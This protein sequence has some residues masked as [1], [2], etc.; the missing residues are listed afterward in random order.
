MFN[1]ESNMRDLPAGGSEIPAVSN[2]QQGVRQVTA[3]EG[4]RYSGTLG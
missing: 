2:P 1:E 3:G 4:V